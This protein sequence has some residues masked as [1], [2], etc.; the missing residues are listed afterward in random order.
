MSSDTE[1][2]SVSPRSDTSYKGSD[3][4][5]STGCSNLSKKSRDKP[6]YADTQISPRVTNVQMSSKPDPFSYF[7]GD[8]GFDLSDMSSSDSEGDCT[9]DN[10]KSFIKNAS[11]VSGVD[12][13]ET[14][15]INKNMSCEKTES[16]V[17]TSLPSATVIFEQ[18]KPPKFI[19]DKSK[20][21]INWDNLVRDN[22]EITDSI[23]INTHSVPPPSSYDSVSDT[24]EPTLGK[25]SKQGTFNKRCS[26]E[27]SSIGKYYLPVVIICATHFIGCANAIA[28]SL[29]H[30]RR[31]K[32]RGGCRGSQ[33][34][35]K[36]WWQ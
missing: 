8:E 4:E 34:L 11:H 6:D 22:T 7:N 18:V 25:V 10:N 17:S 33:D 19:N 20:Q 12:T 24:L 14:T 28:R 1:T 9:D 27:T 23:P 30:I 15:T 5:V 36:G 13:S 21:H 32:F 2:Q 26:S 29:T 31:A 35:T 3:G 16:S